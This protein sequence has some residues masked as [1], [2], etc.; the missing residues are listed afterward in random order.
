M[1]GYIFTQLIWVI[2]KLQ[3]IINPK[4]L[5][6]FSI[7]IYCCAIVFSACQSNKNE[8]EAN[9]IDDISVVTD[10]PEVKYKG[11]TLPDFCLPKGDPLLSVKIGTQEWMV[12]NLNLITFRNG[13]TIPEA[14]TD[15]EWEAAG[16]E[17][18]PAWCYYLNH[19]CLG[20][21]LGKLYNFH[22]IEDERGLAPEG[23]HVP[24]DEEW[25]I[26]TKHLEGLFGDKL[27][28]TSGWFNNGNGTNESGFTALPGG[29]R[30]YD[31]EFM[32]YGD[33]AFFWTG[34]SCVVAHAWLRYLTG[35]YGD[36]N[37]RTK[38]RK[39]AGMSV[40]CVKDYD[41]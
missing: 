4:L 36:K 41:Y 32:Y 16:D 17:G 24:T 28:S 13:D 33:Y 29:I 20:V 18:R 40:R 37:F 15:D 1:K 9:H 11:D 26:L 21:E 8:V 38:A 30:Y 39:G 12:K 35:D 22:A 23:W 34:S 10:Q 27:K 19:S 25:I 5:G 31:G 7:L 14:S 6:C 3:K 2:M